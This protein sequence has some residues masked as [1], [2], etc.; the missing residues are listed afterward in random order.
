MYHTSG[1]DC[2][3]SDSSQGKTAIMGPIPPVIVQKSGLTREE[4]FPAVNR[5]TR[6]CDDS[7]EKSGNL[8][9]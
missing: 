8:E 3:N 4:D 2:E 9:S 1:H 5:G 6:S 7:C